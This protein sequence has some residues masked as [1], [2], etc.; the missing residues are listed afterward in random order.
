MTFYSF[1]VLHL[2]WYLFAIAA[3]WY[4]K[5]ANTFSTEHATKEHNTY[6]N[7]CLFLLKKNVFKNLKLILRHPTLNLYN[8]AIVVDLLT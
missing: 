7:A 4:Y 8:D 1:V 5:G 3:P 2:L 6:T